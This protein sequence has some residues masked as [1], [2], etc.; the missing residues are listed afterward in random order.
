MSIRT[1]LMNCVAGMLAV[2]LGLAAAGWY[3]NQR[4]ANEL[5]LATE[6]IARSAILAGEVRADVVA[7]REKQRGVLMYSF[8]KET[9]KVDQNRGEFRDHLRTAKASLEAARQLST[10]EKGRAMLSAVEVDL[11][12]YSDLFEQISSLVAA[13][14]TMS[15]LAIARDAAGQIGT[16]M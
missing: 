12:K 8:G 9:K 15:A 7:L 2:V 1:K 6:T 4:L 13:R 11:G 10:N 16:R 5:K 3:S 14:K